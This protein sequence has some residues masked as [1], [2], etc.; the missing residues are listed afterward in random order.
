MDFGILRN[1]LGDFFD[2]WKFQNLNSNSQPLLWL[3]K[4]EEGIYTS[5]EELEREKE[6]SNDLLDEI[7]SELKKKNIDDVSPVKDI[8][9]SLTAKP[10]E[11]NKPTPTT[12][13][14]YFEIK[15][16]F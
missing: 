2:T 12:V 13:N 10:T 3:I 15:M 11:S 16:A 8:V 5:I 1:V 6:K 9:P 7:V 14:H 4:E